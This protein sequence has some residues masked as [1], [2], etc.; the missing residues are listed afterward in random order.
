MLDGLAV[1]HFGDFGQDALRSERRA[2]LGEVDVF[3]LPVGGGP[4]IGGEPAAAVV[5]EL[6]PR[7]VVPMHFGTAVVEFLEPP[8]DFLAALG[9]PVTRLGTNEVDTGD[10]LGSRGEPAVALLTPPL[11]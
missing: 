5:R 6:Q 10:V 4:T 1:A 3:F 9:A 8:D 7:L 2:A 11:P